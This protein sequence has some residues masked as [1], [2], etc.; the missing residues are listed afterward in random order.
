[1]CILNIGQS[2]DLL[3]VPSEEI[4]IQRQQWQVEVLVILVKRDLTL[5]QGLLVDILG[6]MSVVAL[7]I[8][9]DIV[10]IQWQMSQMAKQNMS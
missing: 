5:Q 3:T 6:V 9:S 4:E 8:E 2:D 1:M 7:S 10:Y